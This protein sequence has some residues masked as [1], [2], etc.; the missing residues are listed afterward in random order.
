MDTLKE[1]VFWGTYFL[2]IFSQEREEGTKKVMIVVK[3]T[4]FAY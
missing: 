1:A 2:I 3:E 4:R